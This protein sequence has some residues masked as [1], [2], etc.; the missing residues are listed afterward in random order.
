[1]PATFERDPRLGPAHRTG[2]PEA[3]RLPNS[4]GA[5]QALQRAAGNG[6]VAAYV[7][8]LAESPGPVRPP[9]VL[10]HAD[11]RF[12]AVTAKVNAESAR[13]R[14]HPSPRTEAQAASKAAV[15]P[16]ADKES[17][18]KAAQADTMATAKPGGFDKAGFIAAVKA[19][20]AAQAPKNLEEAEDFGKSG[21]AEGV[22]AQVS[23]RVTE[24]K[25][26]S[27]KDIAEATAATP[28]ASKAVEKPVTPLKPE[29]PPAAPKVDPA[30]GMP[31]RAPA[32]QTDL[33]GGKRDTDAALAEADV[34]EQQLAKSNEPEFA[35][36]VAAKREGE[37]HSAAAPAAFREQE[38]ASLSGAGKAANATGAA[39]LAGMLNAKKASQAKAAGGKD[40]AKSKEEQDRAR[41]AG[42]VKA[43]FDATKKDV[44]GILA[45]LDGTVAKQFSE[46][47]QKVRAAFTADL[48]GRMEQYKEARYS[49]VTGKARWL[50]DKLGSLPKEADK[51]YVVARAGYERDMERL[52]GQVADT[53]GRELTRAKDRIAKGRAD[54]TAYVASQ[55]KA[56]QKIAQ[57]AAAQ[58]ESQFDQLENDVDSKKDALVDDLAT[59]YTESKT[60]VD[61][62]ITAMQDE[63]KGLWDKA[64]DA[65]GGAI[66]TV[67]QL[68]DLLV[69]VLARAA[70]AVGKIIKDPIGFLGNFVNAVKGGILGF[71][72]RVGEHLKAGL[73]AWLLGALSAGGIELPAKFDLRGIITLVLSMLGLTWASIRARIVK[74]VP[75]KVMSGVEKAVGF[76]Q[77]ILS[78]GVGGLWKWV[79]EKVGDI[80]AM[81]MGQIRDFVIT[82]IVKAGITWIISLLNPAAA[83]IKACKMI[84]DVVMFFVEKASQIKEFVDSVLDSVE[85][86][87]SGGVGAVAGYIEK[88]LAKM[89]PVLLGF[90][91]SLLGLGGISE[92]I[93]SILETI[94]KPVGK[95]I[96]SLVAGAVRIG[97]GLLKKLANSSFGKKVTA[98]A[99]SAKAKITAAGQKVRDAL[100]KLRERVLGGVSKP[101]TAGDGETHRVFSQKGK[102]DQ[103][104]VASSPK[105]L[106]EVQ[107]QALQDLNREYGDL[108]R[109]QVR[110][111]NASRSGKVSASAAAQLKGMQKRAAAI[112]QK[113]VALV[114][115]AWDQEPAPKELGKVAPHGSQTRPR[116]GKGKLRK[117][118]SEH[119]IP[120]AFISY[121]FE[122][123][124]KKGLS[125]AEY[126]ALTTV[127]TY[128]SAAQ[129]KD[130]GSAPEVAGPSA[131]GDTSLTQRVSGR[132]KEGV[133]IGKAPEKQLPGEAPAAAALRRKAES[134][135]IA[136]RAFKTLA[137]GVIVRTVSAVQSD[138]TRYKSVRV[139]NGKAEEMVPSEQRIRQ[140]A[141]EELADADR[142]AAARGLKGPSSA[143]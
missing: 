87:A 78:E 37:Q 36:A 18:A 75:E 71:A 12:R 47:E 25:A 83:F 143:L 51:I 61:E 142:F 116:P 56:L 35:Q 102:P 122:A 50:S 95:V 39:S 29:P 82:K 128:K 94:Q 79:V 74:K 120:R 46:G 53:I 13:L 54:I 106:T 125:S 103:L 66:R 14:K 19:A 28:D 85:S 23:G 44:D 31:A 64:K 60:A 30:A 132:L 131:T 80:K 7:Q 34:S 69:S 33:S 138:H 43:I 88:T 2:P 136:T 8:R 70:A 22:K 123:Q 45:A 57:G 52:I 15:P 99:R 121:Y 42:E 130:P 62:Q 127:L 17:Q 38:G 119:V 10:P 101:F 67:L 72:E 110:L 109:Q 65:V 91:A 114:V 63:N 111:L 117:T 108:M 133:G 92:K 135:R 21:K 134:E 3:R 81:V 93:K 96:D 16:A 32:E 4:P 1:M 86:I 139:V 40:A 20:I 76:I 105:P 41:I 24:G 77:I 27:A 58:F 141:K 26:A 89:V 100:S 59:K 126:K 97:K 73:Q 11:P 48:N 68:K 129:I 104:Y 115:K 55:P 118:W 90:L 49:G 9:A 98:G 84:Y 137:N 124:G 140:A 112:V 113:I 5:V 6:A 107:N